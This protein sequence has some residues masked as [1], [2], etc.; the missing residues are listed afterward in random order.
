MAPSSAESS[1]QGR[2][3]AVLAGTSAPNSQRQ[4]YKL[5]RLIAHLRSQIDLDTRTHRRQVQE[6]QLELEYATIELAKERRARMEHTTTLSGSRSARTEDT[7]DTYAALW[8]LIGDR[9]VCDSSFTI[10]NFPWPTFS[11]TGLESI[12]AVALH[13]FILHR[14][15]PEVQAKDSRFIIRDEVFKY[16]PDRFMSTVIPLFIS[17]HRQAAAQVASSITIILIG[18]LNY[19]R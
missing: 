2:P 14:T 10:H 7:L 15:R 6:L 8:R 9:K 12:T 19:Y 5:K 3:L 18:F 13:E 16:H 17:E 1:A 11:F 4:T